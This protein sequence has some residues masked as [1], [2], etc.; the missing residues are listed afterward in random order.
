VSYILSGAWAYGGQIVGSQ[1]ACCQAA[2]QFNIYAPGE[3]GP[4]NTDQRNRV[5]LTGVF[6][7]PGGIQLSPVFQAASALPYTL[8]SGTDSNGDGTLNDRYVDPATGQQ[9]ASNSQR[10]DP[11][12]MLNMR[13]TKSITMAGKRKLNLFVEGYNLTNRANFGS[14]Y[15][16]NA[17]SVDFK[18][19][20]GYAFGSYGYPFQLQLGAR[21]EF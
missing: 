7:L 21:F 12:V 2:N 15:N 8:T 13:A 6:D 5:V 19:P 10:G 14:N 11:F 9:V 18:Q 16:G 20:V 4:A 3:W 1:A 17:L